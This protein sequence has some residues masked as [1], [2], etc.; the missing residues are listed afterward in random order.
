MNALS[1]YT[2]STLPEEVVDALFERRFTEDIAKK[3]SLTDIVR[4][5]TDNKYV[6]E[7]A[8]KYFG[9]NGWAPL[10]PEFNLKPFQEK[11]IKWMIEREKGMS[12]GIRGGVLSMR[13]GLGK[14]LTSAMLALTFR[15]QGPTLVVAQKT[16]MAE[17]KNQLGKFFDDTLRVCYF[18][19]EYMPKLAL[20]RPDM[21]DEYDLVITT[22]DVLNRACSEGR[23][24]ASCLEYGDFG[25][26]HE[27]KVVAVHERGPKS[28][29]FLDECVKA[30]RYGGVIPDLDAGKTTTLKPLFTGYGAVYGYPWYRIIADEAQVFENHKSNMY[31]AMLAIPKTVAWCLTGTP[32]RNYDT[33]IWALLRFCGYSGV[34]RAPEWK[35][36]GYSTFKK[37]GLSDAFFYMSYEE[38][39]VT[40]PDK[41]D[42]I[43]HIE[44]DES[45]RKVYTGAIKA[46]GASMAK[47]G[48]GGGEFAEVLANFTLAREACISKDMI[49]EPPVD[50][51]LQ[52][53]IDDLL[54]E[55]RRVF[56]ERRSSVEVQLLP[57]ATPSPIAT[58]TAAEG[59]TPDTVDAL[60][61][62]FTAVTLDA[63]PPP[64][65][66]PTPV[67]ADVADEYKISDETLEKIAVLSRQFKRR[68]EYKVTDFDREAC[69]R[70][71]KIHTLGEMI[72]TSDKKTLVFT[73]FVKAIKLTAAELE[74]RG[75][76]YVMLHGKTT[77]RERDFLLNKFRT[78]ET[79]KVCIL[80]YKV[81]STGLNL[82]EATQCICIEPWWSPVVKDQAQARA[83]RIGQMNVVTTYD[84]IAQGTVEEKIMQI[85]NDKRVLAE[86]YK[87][88]SGRRR[89]RTA[90]LTMTDIMDIVKGIV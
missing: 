86:L 67:V 7:G 27:G 46:L 3:M 76:K 55:D 36:R 40:L 45:E 28:R 29:D 85:A 32:V 16:V 21:F 41:V 64:T 23:Y 75:I 57:P 33:D 14:T 9:V 13:M 73:F 53:M 1:A 26:I 65:P 54:E 78:D 38:A 74:R 35:Q 8:K 90:G 66:A 12:H 51:E 56:E 17:W 63:I 61:T 50:P 87:N 72:E 52:M 79:V 43:V 88:S 19:R 49:E 39:E 15:G 59:V 5:A 71:T 60:A 24:D 22:Y 20:F 81:G 6:R 31:C 62:Q 44:L 25:T 4:M 47:M 37:D 58:T 84:L 18:H 82:T 10:K 68:T 30:S 80:Q 11:A 2:P 70:S 34:T 89:A 77:Q 42:Q 69:Q 83:W 48:R